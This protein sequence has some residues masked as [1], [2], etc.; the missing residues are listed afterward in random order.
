MS[1]HAHFSQDSKDPKD[2]LDGKREHDDTNARREESLVPFLRHVKASE[3]PS[4]PAV[5]EVSAT[6]KPV[7]AAQVL[8]DNHI[9]GA[10][11]WDQDKQKYVG[12]FDMRDLLSTVILYEQVK[13]DANEPDLNVS[14]FPEHLH[15]SY[16]AARNHLC[17]DYHHDSSLYDL[18]RALTHKE[19]RMVCLM[20]TETQRV[21]RILTRTYM[22]RYL[23]Q[24]VAWP[25]VP[26]SDTTLLYR[27][28]VVQAPDTTSARDVFRL[29]DQ[30]RMSGIAI[31][32]QETGKL[33]GNTS[34]TDIKAALHRR[35]HRHQA[36]QESSGQE[37]QQDD[38]DVNLDMDILSY[39][40]QVRQ[41]SLLD[42][43][44]SAHVY[45]SASL[46]HAVHMLA[47][48]GFHRV[49][50]VDKD[51]RPI[52]VISVADIIQYVVNRFEQEK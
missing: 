34:A 29:M 19:T 23:A 13:Q 51:V 47:K 44:P 12:I 22:V 37:E 30:H 38:N 41:H 18:L 46:D 15:T 36:D 4:P 10:P 40:A 43:Y 49:F 45:E 24:Q 21:A 39:L 5:V 32:D 11:V 50:V 6:M 14:W 33:V 7:D 42:R 31:V 1:K 3:V 20:N 8:W 9:M 52:G 28:T 35:R 27:K 2:E 16:L 25:K 48:T 17:A 26:L